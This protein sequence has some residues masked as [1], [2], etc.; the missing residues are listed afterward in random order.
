MSS[1][2]Y[3]YEN[4]APNVCILVRHKLS[5]QH[6]WRTQWRTAQQSDHFTHAIYRE[7]K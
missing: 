5:G 4:Y 1:Q 3:G 7:I 2:Q 6:T